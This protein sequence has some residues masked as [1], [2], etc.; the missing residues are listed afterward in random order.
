MAKILITAGATRNPIDSMRFISAN[1]SG[2]T[3]A[4]I[5]S[6]LVEHEITVLCSPEAELRQPSHTRTAVFYSTFDLLE[7]IKRWVIDNPKG[8]VF[9]CAAVGDYSAVP[10]DIKIPSGQKELTVVLTPTPKILD[11]IRSWSTDIWLA[12]FKAAGPKTNESELIT[13]AEK[14]MIRSKSDAVFGNVIGNIT[15][16]VVVAT[17][18]ETKVF[19]DRTDG[20]HALVNEFSQHSSA[21]AG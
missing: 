12:S 21:T 1:S 3:G 2:T 17:P 16:G 8:A 5:A 4:W 13:I 7:K 9:H 18:N 20:L 14:Q 15:N 10:T 11:R 6:H 19:A